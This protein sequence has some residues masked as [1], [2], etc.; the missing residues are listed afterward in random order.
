MSASTTTVRSRRTLILS[1]P[2]DAAIA[3][4]LAGRLSARGSGAEVTAYTEGASS[5]D[6]TPVAQVVAI[7]PRQAADAGE[8]RARFVRMIGRLRTAA[9]RSRSAEGL[10][11]V[12]FGG[13]RFGSGEAPTDIEA[14]GASAFARS[15]HLERPGQRVRAID[16]APDIT[17][18]DAAAFVESELDGPARFAAVGRDAD[19]TRLVPRARLRPMAADRPRSGAWT[20]DDVVLVTGGAKG[21]TAECALALGRSQGVRLVLVGSTPA[22]PEGDAG[23]L[24]ATLA[25]FRAGGVSYRY[26]TCEVTDGDAVAEL[27]RRVRHQVGPITGVVH[28]AG[29]NRPRRADQVSID[30]AMA[31]VGPKLLGAAHLARALAVAPPRLFLAFSSI[32]GVTGMPGNA[33]YGFSNEVLDLLVRRFATD[34]PETAALSIAFSVWGETGMGARLG[35]VDHLGKMGIGAIPT[36]EGVRRFLHFFDADPGAGQV[37]VTA[38][39]GGLDTWPMET[40]A[41]PRGLRF[42][43]SLVRWMPGVE[44]VART[45]LTL[46]RDV[47]V[48]DHV[49]KGSYLFPTVFGLEAMTQAAAVVTG[50]DRPEVGRIGDIRLDR[51]IVVDPSRGVEIEIRAEALEP[52]VDGEQPV[53]VGIRTEQTGFV[54][55]HFAA[56]LVLSERAEGPRVDVPRGEPLGL[57]PKVD[58]YGGLLFQ[59]PLS[60]RMGRIHELD[61]DHTIFESECRP[62]A[63]LAGEA[64]AARGRTPPGRPVLS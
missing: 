39:L 2:H 60:Q 29:V 8:E 28:A 18:A 40:P 46:E 23:E 57:D 52:T 15:V 51:P 48:K 17:P 30:E 7:L 45:R 62:A 58:L 10:A 31:E 33:W 54:A 25:R 34:H 14:C 16:L 61:S 6:D 44:L 43:E 56:T 21:I 38:R 63:D 55:D 49:Y 26:E 13:G 9:V 11:I 36:E 37:V 47:Y 53:R 3:Q 50:R 5:G 59:G 24:A 22:P 35:S 32:I 1:D 19:G 42:V 41:P 64:F 12:Q 27:L 20:S 4:A